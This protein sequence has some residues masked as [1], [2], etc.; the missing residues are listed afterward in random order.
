M[1][2][3]YKTNTYGNKIKLIACIVAAVLAF[4]LV[5]GLVFGLTKDKNAEIGIAGSKGGAQLSVVNAQGISLKIAPIDLEGLEPDEEGEE[6]DEDGEYEL[7]PDAESAYYLTAT[8]MP[9]TV[10]NRLI[11]WT[12]VFNNPSAEWAADK[13]VT[14]YVKLTPISDDTAVLECMGA[15]GEQIKVTAASDKDETKTA[16]CIV[17][18]KQKIASV[19]VTLDQ[20]I[21]SPLDGGL[22]YQ[23]GRRIMQ[24][25]IFPDSENVNNA[26]Y[27]VSY[28]MSE[29]YTIKNDYVP[30][31]HFT[32]TV[33]EEFISKLNDAGYKTTSMPEVSFGFESQ[34]SGTVNNFFDKSWISS[35]LG[36]NVTAERINALI[37]F[38]DECSDEPVF[39]LTAYE[40]D[41][42]D[43][44]YSYD[45]WLD[46]TVLMEQYQ[47]ENVQMGD[48]NIVF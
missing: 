35:L 22:S 36:G 25:R 14:D 47:V 11:N 9:E 8:V 10:T 39:T 46:V 21:Y 43:E 38:L 12:I 20:V 34:M 32:F 1:N 23:D 42:G 44:V 48:S 16:N 13:T 30:K 29:V 3:N 26:E 41:G 18:Y 17:D 37:D 28:E 4:A 40:Y 2:N 5:A 27:E 19:S 15:F 7:D 33:N 31:Y 24:A 6:G 45:G